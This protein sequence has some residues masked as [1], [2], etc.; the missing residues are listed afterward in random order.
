MKNVIYYF[1]GTGNSLR[2]A[3][4]KVNP[5]AYFF[6]VSL[7]ALING[8]C[9][10][11]LAKLLQKKHCKLSYGEKVYSVANYVAMYPPFPDPVRRVPKTEEKLAQIAQEV[12]RKQIRQYPQANEVTKWL[13]ARIEQKFIRNCPS[14]DTYFSVWNDCISCGLCAKVCPC[15][16]IRMENGRP[17][18]L[19][20]CSQCMACISFCPQQ[21]INFPKFTRKRKK[22]HNPHITAENVSSDRTQYS[23]RNTDHSMIGKIITVTIDRPL[24]SYHPEHPEMYYPVNYGYVKGIMAPDGEEQD[25]YILGVE[26]PVET[27]TGKIIAIVHR[28]NDVEEKWVVCPEKMSFTEEEIREKIFFQE[29]YFDS[30]ILMV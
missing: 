5:E 16:N 11:T 30:H 18:F 13:S 29:Q 4:V 6:A 2:A 1:T 14:N 12:G 24:G 23:S 17:V 7:P 10:D 8:V 9:Q 26:E 22:Y 28:N 25:A 3:Q 15:H 20:Q 21:A 27:F 19:H